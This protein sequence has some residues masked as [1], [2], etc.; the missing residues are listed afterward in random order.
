MVETEQEVRPFLVRQ[1]HNYV[2][3]DKDKEKVLEN[4]G[5]RSL[6]P[7]LDHTFKMVNECRNNL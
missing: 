7:S 2:Q 4:T 3:K 1:R 6:Y 5:T